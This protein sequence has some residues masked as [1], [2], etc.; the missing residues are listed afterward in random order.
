VRDVSDSR[1]PPVSMWRRALRLLVLSLV[2]LC[3]AEVVLRIVFD[4]SLFIGD[5]ESKFW[6]ADPELG[7]RHPSGVTGVFTNGFF[8]G[9]ITLGNHG[10]RENSKNGT[11]DHEYENLLF[12]GDSTTASF[13]VDD[14][15]TVPALLEHRLRAAGLLFNVIN[16][17]V[18]GYGT[19]QSVK[20]ALEELKFF[21]SS[22]VIYYFTGNDFDNNNTVRR[23]GRRF[24]KSVF[25]RRGDGES[26]EEEYC[27]VPDWPASRFIHVAFDGRCRPSFEIGDSYL[28]EH[29][30]RER[31]EGFGRGL[32][33]VRAF[34]RIMYN[35]WLR[36]E[37]ERLVDFRRERA[38][39]RDYLGDQM[40]FLMRKLT[41]GTIDH[42]SV[43]GLADPD[44]TAIFDRLVDDGVID[45]FVE[46]RPAF[47]VDRGGPDAF[48]CQNDDHFCAEG[49]E[50][51][52]DYVMALLFGSFVPPIV[53][54]EASIQ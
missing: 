16:L 26:F 48:R 28:A 14:D 44:A 5:T 46:L 47:P 17:G 39:C 53:P 36:T 25:V 22:R 40:S 50:K 13:E 27:P 2:T 23:R 7:W 32:Y 51:I 24:G 11:F 52:A 12:I 33:V 34:N 45:R 43:I 31:V 18:R 20:L 21:P 1:R 4:D 10:Q 6:I 54:S 19:D 41:A 35:W 29:F 49:N 8:E 38:R 42:A 3:L 30:I 37:L 15:Q 9:R